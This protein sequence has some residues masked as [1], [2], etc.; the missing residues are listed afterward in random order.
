M[1]VRRLWGG[2]CEK[3]KSEREMR[4]FSLKIDGIEWFGASQKCEIVGSEKGSVVYG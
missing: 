2:G 3:E 1:T 4:N